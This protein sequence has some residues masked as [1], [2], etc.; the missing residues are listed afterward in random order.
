MQKILAA[1]LVFGFLAAIPS[2]AQTA[3]HRI[4]GLRRPLPTTQR[5]LAKVAV[6]DLRDG[7]VVV[8]EDA[9]PSPLPRWPARNGV[10]RLLQ[11]VP[12]LPPAPWMDMSRVVS[13]GNTVA[14]LYPLGWDVR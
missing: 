6:K 5:A 2:S 11:P 12:A 3:T 9:G 8:V 1:F 10:F 14:L 4:K 13:G 7:A